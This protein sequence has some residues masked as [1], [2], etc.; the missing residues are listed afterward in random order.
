VIGDKDELVSK[1]RDFLD[2]PTGAAAAGGG[3]G[4]FRWYAGQVALAGSTAWDWRPTPRVLLGVLAW[5][6]LR[7][8][9]SYRDLRPRQCRPDPRHTR[10]WKHRWNRAPT[11]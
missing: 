7:L 1:M 10:P 5:L 4:L 9:N 6:G 8:R 3:T 2:R 11:I